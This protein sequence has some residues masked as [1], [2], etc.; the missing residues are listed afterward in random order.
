MAKIPLYSRSVLERLRFIKQAQEHG[1]TLKE[2]RQLIAY[3]DDGGRAR[4][5]QVRNLLK[6]KLSELETNLVQLQEFQSDGEHG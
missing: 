6:E 1:L 2:I 3:Q 4:C 5:R